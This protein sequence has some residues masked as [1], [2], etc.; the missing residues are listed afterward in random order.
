MPWQGHHR[1]QFVSSVMY[2]S[3]AKFEDYCSNT[4]R[5]I[6]DFVFYNFS[7]TV[8]YVITLLI[9]MIQNRCYLYNENRYAKKQKGHSPVFVKNPSNKQQLI[10]F[11]FIGTIDISL[12]KPE[13]FS[14]INSSVCCLFE[15]KRSFIVSCHQRVD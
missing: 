3:G 4:S 10:V 15:P 1:F 8:Y 5:D 2:I 13:L 14:G 11:H 6:L 7:C 12:S 9:C